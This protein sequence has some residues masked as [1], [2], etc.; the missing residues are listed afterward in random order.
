MRSERNS[1]HGWINR[2]LL[3]Y[4]S[5][6]TTEISTRVNKRALNVIKSPVGY[7][8]NGDMIEYIQNG[9]IRIADLP[10][11]GETHKEGT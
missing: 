4:K 10:K 11:L 5:S 8:G 7:V 1:K 9:Y 2:V 3:G 6:K